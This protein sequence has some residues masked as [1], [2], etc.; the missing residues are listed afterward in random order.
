MSKDCNGDCNNCKIQ[1][2]NRCD[3]YINT[4]ISDN[5]GEEE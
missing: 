1:D 3:A 2:K 4:Q 5:Y